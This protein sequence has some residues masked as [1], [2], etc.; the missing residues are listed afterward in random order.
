MLKIRIVGNYL[1]APKRVVR[2]LEMYL[3]EKAVDQRNR[4]FLED[5]VTFRALLDG[6]TRQFPHAFLFDLDIVGL[7]VAHAVFTKVSE[8][9]LL[10]AGDGLPDNLIA[11][12]AY[13]ASTVQARCSV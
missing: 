8:A 9:V 7:I 12:E 5:V 10:A 4:S 1:Y 3:G 2:A 13:V 11:D 6:F